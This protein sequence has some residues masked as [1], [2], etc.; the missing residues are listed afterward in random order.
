MKNLLIFVPA[1]FGSVLWNRASFTVLL[2]GF[3]GFSLLSSAVYLHN[4]LADRKEDAKHPEKCKRPIASGAIRVQTAVQLSVLLFAFGTGILTLLSIKAC[5]IGL[6]YVLL[7]ILYTWFMK[8]LAIVDLL[9]LVQGYWLRLI[10][11]SVL[12][13][14]PLSAW[15][16]AVISLLA[17]YLVLHKRFGDVQIFRQSGLVLRRSITVY[18]SLPLKQILDGL[19]L[20]IGGLFLVYVIVVFH[21]RSLDFHPWVYASVPLNWYAL[22]RFH[23]GLRKVPTRDPLVFIFRSFQ[24]LFPAAIAFVVL[25]LSLY[26]K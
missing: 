5:M 6:G 7:N 15:V 13:G 26:L 8:H 14:P 21:M 1:I 10:L 11:G 17:V 25:C 3:I 19:A 18:A 20:S 16:L 22:Y 24:V 4:D 2:L 12:A 23:F 9:F